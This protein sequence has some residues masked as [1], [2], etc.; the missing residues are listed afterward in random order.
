MTVIN[1]KLIVQR[2]MS[3]YMATHQFISIAGQWQQWFSQHAPNITVRGIVFEVHGGK[4]GEFVLG[5]VFLV[6]RQRDGHFIQVQPILWYHPPSLVFKVLYASMK[7]RLI[8][9]IK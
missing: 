6:V 2:P 7:G 5:Q 3:L 9:I 4:L 8:Q 1:N